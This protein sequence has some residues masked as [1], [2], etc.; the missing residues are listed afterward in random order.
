M[1]PFPWD[2]NAAAMLRNP[3]S[4]RPAFL[5]A[6]HR[7]TLPHIIVSSM[8]VIDSVIDEGDRYSLL[9]RFASCAPWLPIR[10][11]RKAAV[12]S[13]ER[14]LTFSGQSPA[15]RPTHSPIPLSPR[16][17]PPAGANGRVSPSLITLKYCYVPLSGRGLPIAHDDRLHTQALFAFSMDTIII[18]RTQPPHRYASGRSVAQAVSA[19]LSFINSSIRSAMRCAGSRSC[20]TVHSA[21]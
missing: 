6:V 21:A 8:K 5:Q 9:A 11:G 4:R 7:S 12:G 14:P 20:P 2:T 16:E 13:C 15:R 17:H 18:D 1:Q 3:S 19:P 10:R